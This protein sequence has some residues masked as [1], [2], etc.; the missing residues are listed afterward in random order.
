V[1]Y[2]PDPYIKNFMFCHMNII[3]KYYQ[4]NIKCL[5]SIYIFLIKI[6][7]T[8]YKKYIKYIKKIYKLK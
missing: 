1:F 5:L 8:I 6:N 7:S 3:N 4:Y 2:L